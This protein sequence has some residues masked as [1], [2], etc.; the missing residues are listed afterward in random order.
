MAAKQEADRQAAHARQ[1]ALETSIA[2]EALREEMARRQEV[3][4]RLEYLAGHDPLTGLPNRILFSDRLDREMHI[5][6]RAGRRFALLYLDLDHFKNVNDTLGHAV[7]DELLKAVG[8]RLEGIVRDIDTVARLGGDEF[9]ILQ[10]SIG[11]ADD[12][13]HLAQQLIDGLVEPFK[14]GGRQIFTGAS[15]GVTIFPDDGDAL[16]QLHRHA[17]LA[18]YRAKHEGRN[19]YHFFDAQ[20]NASVHRR[21][22]VEQALHEALDSGQISL[23]Y[24]PQINLATGLVS[25][26]EA[27]MRWNHP[28]HGTLSPGEFIPIAESSGMITELGTWAL[29]EACRQAIR[30]NEAGLSNLTIAVNVAVAQFKSSDVPKIVAE[31]LAETGLPPAQL[32]LEI[33]E[34]GVM[35]DITDANAILRAL[36][37]IGVK[38]AIDDFGTGYSSLSYLRSMPV[39]RLKIDR[40][41]I[42][43]APEDQDAAS[44]ATTIVNL[45]QNLRLEVI[46]EGVETE[47]H[48]RF[49]K[50]IGCDTAQGYYY[51]MPGTAEE[52]IRLAGLG[53]LGPTDPFTPAPGD[54][55]A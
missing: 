23:A 27:L 14:V 34:S 33:T 20:M 15:V 19:T 17:D 47:A 28:E 39:D 2:N 51:G 26:A 9:A 22:Q 53:P 46:A 55:A 24:Q 4:S 7:G 44:I 8:K 12:S 10:A 43:D 37:D 21:A 36:R 1:S 29:R 50:D 25:G 11:N 5:A 32:E 31:V 16:D 18:M 35:Q 45:A 38:L 52:L 41:F 13:R 3:Q 6:R 40:S 54:Q 30:W 48:A 42:T 49:V